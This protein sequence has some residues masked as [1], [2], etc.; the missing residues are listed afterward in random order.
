MCRSGNEGAGTSPRRCACNT[1]AVNRRHRRYAQKAYARNVPVTP[2]KSYTTPSGDHLP[3]MESILEEREALKELIDSQPNFNSLEEQDAWDNELESRVTGL[4]MALARE[5]EASID[6]DFKSYWEERDVPSEELEALGEQVDAAAVV[7]EELIESG[8][9]EEEI[10]KAEDNFNQ[11]S[12]QF[13]EQADTDEETSS[14]REKET[15]EAL[16]D[17]YRTHLSQIRVLGGE[18]IETHATSDSE[19]SETLNR[20]IQHYY[21][22][23]WIEA[24]NAEG[25][26]RVLPVKDGNRPHCTKNSVQEDLEANDYPEFKTEKYVAYMNIPVPVEELDKELEIL[27]N[28]ATVLEARPIPLNGNWCYIVQMPHQ[29]IL[30]PTVDSVDE[31]GVPTEPGWE[32]ANYIDPATKRATTEKKYV[33][34]S[35][36][37]DTVSMT[38]MAIKVD[39]EESDK[40]ALKATALHEFGHRAENTVKNGLLMRQ[41]EAF[42]RRR[43]TDPETGEREDLSQVY[44]NKPANGLLGTEFGRRN[45]FI[46][47]YIGKEYV[48]SHNRE[49]L[50]V[51]VESVFAGSLGG[52]NGLDSNLRKTD[53]DLKGFILGLFATV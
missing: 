27:G 25:G 9:P 40:R 13:A 6:F 26:L 46:H 22:K 49:V 38:E 1:S 51:G 35:P 50:T 15:L 21:P 32:L 20:I 19:A 47:H 44:P 10:Q 37:I 7:L 16:S 30:D 34:T 4:G 14:S 39:S 2:N 48:T 17:A 45:S 3:D 36:V 43:T 31:N 23:E 52:L 18:S 8:A 42:L 29:K 33:K 24:S 11:L 28:K 53:N 5:A 12:E 41:E